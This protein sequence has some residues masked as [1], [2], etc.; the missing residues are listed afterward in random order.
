MGVDEN[1]A[2]R[3][4]CARVRQSRSVAGHRV[5]RLDVRARQRHA[6]RHARAERM[7]KSA[8]VRGDA[9]G[10]FNLGTLYDASVQPAST[11]TGSGRRPVDAKLSQLWYKRAARQGQKDAMY[12]MGCGPRTTDEQWAE[13]RRMWRQG[14][15]HDCPVSMCALGSSMY[16]EWW[17]GY[18]PQAG[19]LWHMKAMVLRPE[20][21]EHAA[22]DGVDLLLP[23]RI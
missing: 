17:D 7:F 9:L 12:N 23:V 22:Y 6:R 11:G 14:A 10:Q 13:A 21:V 19:V 3:C 18:N 5:R 2:E 1:P 8:A 16:Q 20:C 4:V 15:S